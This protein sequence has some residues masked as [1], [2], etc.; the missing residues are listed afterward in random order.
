MNLSKQNRRRIKLLPVRIKS[1]LIMLP[2]LLFSFSVAAQN[3]TSKNRRDTNKI[4]IVDSLFTE[5]LDSLQSI[6]DADSAK[7]EHDSAAGKLLS[8]LKESGLEIEKRNIAEYKDDTIATRQ[9]AIIEEIR[10][11][12]LESENY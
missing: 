11:L 6:Y 12:T 3:D 2:V 1:I 9:D 10:R 4:E 5:P 8:Y 7:V